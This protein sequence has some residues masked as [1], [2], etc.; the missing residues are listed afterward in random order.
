M[1]GRLSRLLLAGIKLTD[2]DYRVITRGDSIGERPHIE[3]F[4]EIIEL[5]AMVGLRLV[6][7]SI[8][9]IINLALQNYDAE[10]RGDPI[11]E[12][13]LHRVFLGSPGIIIIIIII[14]L[15]LLSLLL[16]SILLLRYW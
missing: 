11:Q 6:K 16:L 14:S 7:E 9:N 5:K 2:Y 13:S 8:Y 3:D 1:D 15:L 12:I 4:P 10:M